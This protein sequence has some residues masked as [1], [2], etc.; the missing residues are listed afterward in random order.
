MIYADN[1]F[2]LFLVFLSF[3]L[4]FFLFVFCFFVVVAAEISVSP[5]AVVLVVVS[6]I[7]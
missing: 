2:N 5:G 7:E 6:Q 4:S 3:F 1:Y